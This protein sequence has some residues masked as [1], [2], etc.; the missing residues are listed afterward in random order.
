MA[1]RWMQA[2]MQLA[3]RHGITISGANRPMGA[4]SDDRPLGYV[5]PKEHPIC[6]KPRQ[7]KVSRL[8]KDARPIA[9]G[10]GRKARRASA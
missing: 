2:K 4:V 7:G 9:W 6:A 5:E 10:Q 8:P 3:K 1:Q